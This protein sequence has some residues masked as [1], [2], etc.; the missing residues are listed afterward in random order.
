M[1]FG[2]DIEDDFCVD[3]PNLPYKVIYKEEIKRQKSFKIK[4]TD[5]VISFVRGKTLDPK[6]Q[7]H[8]SSPSKS[9]K[10]GTSSA[11][12]KQ[13]SPMRHRK[14]IVSDGSSGEENSFL[15]KSNNSDIPAIP[16]SKITF[17]TS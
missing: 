8:S 12:S 9:A 3:E 4:A 5:P 14:V 15:R 13:L 6:E 11:E 17:S 2:F 7:E 10:P 1:V 16:K